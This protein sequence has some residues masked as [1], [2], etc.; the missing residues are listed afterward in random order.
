MPLGPIRHSIAASTP[1]LLRRQ[2]SDCPSR[3]GSPR[4]DFQFA[5]S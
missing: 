3:R 5:L 4:A 2:L 1:D